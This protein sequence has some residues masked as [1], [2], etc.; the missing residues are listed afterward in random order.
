M[1]RHI[2]EHILRLDG[3]TDDEAVYHR[4]QFV[5][6]A[7]MERT[8][9]G[10]EVRIPRMAYDEHNCPPHIKLMIVGPEY[11][12]QVDNETWKAYSG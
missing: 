7:T 1:N 10:F 12:E 11:G 9:D 2:T 6:A 3:L 8:H 5:D 4:L